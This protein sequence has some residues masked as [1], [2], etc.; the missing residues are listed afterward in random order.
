MVIRRNEECKF[1]YSRRFIVIS[2]LDDLNTV[3]I[4]IKCHERKVERAKFSKTDSVS[5]D[6]RHIL[7]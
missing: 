2:P 1:I 7:G 5:L 6:T 3:L 4:K